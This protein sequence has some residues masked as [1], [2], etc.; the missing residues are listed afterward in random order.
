MDSG[1]LTVLQ[2]I[3]LAG[4]VGHDAKLGSATIIRKSPQGTMTETPVHLK[5]ILEAKAADHSHASRTTFCS[6]P[7]APPSGLR[8]APPKPLFRRLPQSPF[9]QCIPKL[10]RYAATASAGRRLPRSW[11]STAMYVAAVCSR[12]KC[13]TM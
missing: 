9:L 12:E 11:S 5:K 3:A 8:A 2:A 6:F 4:G 1:S 13:S 7:P 10:Y